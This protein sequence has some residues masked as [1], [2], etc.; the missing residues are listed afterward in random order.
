MAR[1]MALRALARRE[2]ARAELTAHLTSRGVATADARCVVED[3]GASGL[4]SDA[5][6]A[7]MLVQA[8]RRRGYGPVRIAAE[9]GS[10]GVAREVVSAA[11]EDDDGQWTQAARDWL[12]RHAR[13]G[14]DDRAHAHTLRTRGF[15]ADQ[16]R[17]ALHEP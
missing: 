6:Y 5:R 11:L 8:R 17:A 15:T 16:A 7:A 10:A 1:A 14:R 12:R 4:Q 2:Y 3:L 9:L 13:P